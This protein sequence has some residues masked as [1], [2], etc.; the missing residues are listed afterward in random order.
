[1]LPARKHYFTHARTDAVDRPIAVPLAARAGLLGP[2]TVA[3]SRDTATR[4][5]A[6]AVDSWLSGA[7]TSA[8][9][10]SVRGRTAAVHCAGQVRIPASWLRQVSG[11]D[12]A[13]GHPYVQI[14]QRHPDGHGTRA[15][16]DTLRHCEHSFAA[17]YSSLHPAMR[18]TRRYSFICDRTNCSAALGPTC[19]ICSS[20]C[21][22]M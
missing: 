4:M 10:E 12:D 8:F 15:Y 2:D 1:M 5:T 16:S 9:V 18:A 3:T 7:V 20:T 6:A 13:A 19:R 17:G 11:D 14:R 22:G 21:G